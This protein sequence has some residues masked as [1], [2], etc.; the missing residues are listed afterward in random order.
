[1]KWVVVAVFPCIG[2]SAGEVSR[3]EPQHQTHTLLEMQSSSLINPSI[4]AMVYY[5]VLSK[6]CQ[7]CRQRK[8]KV[9]H[10]PKQ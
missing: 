1:M 10:H 5:G 2:F 4:I 8:V 7:R 9:T 3:A 6:G